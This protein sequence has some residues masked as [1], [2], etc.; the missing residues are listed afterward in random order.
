VLT[1]LPRVAAAD[2]QGDWR[3]SPW[4]DGRGV[5]MGVADDLSSL[6]GVAAG[7]NLLLVVLESAGA[8]YLRPYGAVDDPMPNLTRLAGKGLVVERA[9]VVYP[10]SIKGL[11]AMLS[12]AWPAFGTEPE[13]YAR[14]PQ[15]ALGTVLS[16]AG[17]RTGLFHSGRFMYLGMDAMIGNR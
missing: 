16:R 12:S 8:G 5:D 4:P 7:R 1:A 3:R 11:H 17:Y 15:P 10:E 9:Y 6:R 13:A 14:W 2:A